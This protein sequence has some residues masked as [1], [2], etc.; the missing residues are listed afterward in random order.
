MQTLATL[1]T[2]MSFDFSPTRAKISIIFKQG[3]NCVYVIGHQ[4]P[5]IYCKWLSGT[6]DINR[7]SQSTPNIIVT[8]K[9]S[10][11]MSHHS[12]KIRGSSS[13]RAA[14][15]WHFFANQLKR[16]AVPTLHKFNHR[17][18]NLQSTHEQRRDRAR[19]SI[20][21]QAQ[22]AQAPSGI[23]ALRAIRSKQRPPSAIDC[24]CGR[25]RR[26]VR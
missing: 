7:I 18:L 19:L 6:H 20:M 3:P 13:M 16:W 14:I 1:L 21:Q 8:Q 5:S 23:R 10:S 15:I 9:C 12:K 17:L 11:L 4:Y 22:S 26:R 25:C 2:H 24:G